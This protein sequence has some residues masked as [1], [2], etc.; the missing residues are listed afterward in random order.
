[1]GGP[2]VEP[3]A[4]QCSGHSVCACECMHVPLNDVPLNACSI[5]M[6]AVATAPL[7]L[8]GSPSAPVMTACNP[9]RHEIDLLLP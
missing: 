2:A 6:L 3:W 9:A 8:S 1:M 7:P 4:V 5:A